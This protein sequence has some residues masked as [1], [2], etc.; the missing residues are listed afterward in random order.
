MFT[1]D[2]ENLCENINQSVSFLKTVEWNQ[3]GGC[4][5]VYEKNTSYASSII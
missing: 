3:C 4:W 2:E 5:M 1:L